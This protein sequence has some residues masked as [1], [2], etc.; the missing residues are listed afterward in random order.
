MSRTPIDTP[1]WIGPLSM[2]I[3][4]VIGGVGV[5]IIPAPEESFNAP[6]WVVGLCGLVFFAAGFRVQ[7][8]HRPEISRWALLVLVACF[9]AI[10]L[11]VGLFG[12]AEAFG[13]GS[14]LLSTESN[15][16]VARWIFTGGG[17]ACALLLAAM[18]Y[19]F[20]TLR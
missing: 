3:G 18:L 2:L 1:R 15:V 19:N 9:A 6:R 4:L 12:E 8:V 17:A 10:G 16:S 13:G 20:K 11:W 7:T 5:G 14:S